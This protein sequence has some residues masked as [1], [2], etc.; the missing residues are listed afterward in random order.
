MGPGSHSI[1]EQSETLNPGSHGQGLGSL[2]N[3]HGHLLPTQ[4]ECPG[5]NTHLLRRRSRQTEPN[6]RSPRK[7]GSCVIIPHPHAQTP[8]AQSLVQRAQAGTLPTKLFSPIYMGGLP[9]R[10]LSPGGPGKRKG[11]ENGR[12]ME[13]AEHGF[14]HPYP[15]TT[16]SGCPTQSQVLFCLSPLQLSFSE[17]AS[18]SPK[19]CPRVGAGGKSVGGESLLLKGF[20]EDVEGRLRTPWAPPPTGCLYLCSSF[21]LL[22]DSSRQLGIHLGRQNKG[23]P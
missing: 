12:G 8:R 5:L 11:H 18:S 6:T 9:H 7:A 4:Q 17:L 10:L 2:Q 23:K 19:L 15:R 21:W 1:L 3:A 20:T 16:R 22:A 14:Q 13:G